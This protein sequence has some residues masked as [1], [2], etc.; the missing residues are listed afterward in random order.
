[1]SG[2][3]TSR[4]KIHGGGGDDWG[5]RYWTGDFSKLTAPGKYRASV[6]VGSAPV[7]SFPFRIGDELIFRETAMPAANF[8]S[9]QRCGCAV[10]GLHAACHLDDAKIPDGKGGHIDAT[11]G[12]H[13]A[14]DLNKYASIACRTVHALIVL[15][16]SSQGRL[17]DDE[18]KKVLDEALWGA[19]FLRKMWQP[20]KGIIYHDVFSGYD[21]WGNPALQT[22]NVPGTKDDRPLRGEG[23]SAMTAAALAAAAGQTGRRDYRQAAEDL[24]RGACQAIGKDAED[25]WV[26]TS[27]G[28]PDLGQDAPGRRVRRTADLLL[29]DLELQRLTGDARYAEGAKHRVAALVREQNP[30]GLWPSDVY[31]RTV[32]LGVPPAALALYVES[33]HGRNEAADLAKAALGRWLDR[34]LRLADNPFSLIPWSEG[35]FFNPHVVDNWYVGQNSQY[36]SIAWALYLTADVLHRPEARRLADRQLDWVL[37]VNPYGMCMFEGKGSYNPPSFMHQWA[38][39]R[40]RGAVPGAIPNGFCRNA[41]DRADR[42]WFSA[43]LTAKQS[44]FHTAEPWE[45]HNAFFILALTARAARP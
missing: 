32:L 14:G 15:N 21:Y 43:G 37:G 17:S 3:L 1:M 35:V 12:W 7:Y 39:A 2:P 28:V 11:G 42:P 44:D 33:Q 27:G 45:P 26:K 16:R 34:N 19:E 40:E 5:A 4:D 8:F 38:P 31:S 25:P 20:G 41:A 13:D 22:D 9:F 10:P 18:R 36:L 24:W 30:D 23:P 29:A 6:Q